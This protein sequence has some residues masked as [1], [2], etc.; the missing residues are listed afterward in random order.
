MDT[1]VMDPWFA[2]PGKTSAHH[3]GLVVYAHDSLKI[4]V[5]CDA[6]P[7]KKRR[8]LKLVFGKHEPREFRIQPYSEG[9]G[10]LI[11]DQEFR[12]GHPEDQASSIIGGVVQGNV[13]HGSC[14][15]ELPRAS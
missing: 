7:R 12:A 4:M 3:T 15:S 11:E 6:E 13:R 10:K 2:G 14:H 9:L 8:A 5:A 1:K